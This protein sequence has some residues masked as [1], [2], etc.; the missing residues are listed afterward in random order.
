[1]RPPHILLKAFS[2]LNLRLL[3]RALASV[4]W[5]TLKLTSVSWGRR[6]R[7]EWTS[8]RER[9]R[10]RRRNQ[11]GLLAPEKTPMVYG[12]HFN[13][14][15]SRELEG[16]YP[17][18]PR[19]GTWPINYLR[20]EFGWGRV[21][22]FLELTEI[23]ADFGAPV[24]PHLDRVAKEGRIHHYQRVRTA[25][26]ARAL[27]RRNGNLLVRMKQ[28]KSLPPPSERLELKVAFEYT[29][30]FVDAPRGIVAV[31]A[32]GSPILGS[33]SVPIIGV[34]E[35][36]RSF[37][38]SNSWGGWWGESSIGYMSFDFFDNF[39]IESWA[40]DERKP[41]LPQGEEI[42]ILRWDEP[43]PFR[44]HTYGVEIY[45]SREDERIGWSFAV[46]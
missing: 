27:A 23:G 41:S 9:S 16:T 2:P 3:L 12:L 32:P 10:N 36:M 1:M 4:V 5:G 14:I 43:D 40:I 8:L 21:P 33:H 29:Q 11:Q 24:P 26:N 38:F 13:Y 19:L 44:G 15:R 7:Y 20:T 35:P 37:L 28:G 18:D 34:S 6:D 17:G 30:E 31:P 45:D 22:R 42:V 39:M 25:Y 46:H